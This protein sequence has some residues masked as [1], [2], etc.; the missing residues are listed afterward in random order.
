MVR[1]PPLL[2]VWLP[3]T[4]RP[5]RVEALAVA[6]RVEVM[7]KTPPAAPPLA[8]T[9][10]KSPVWLAAPTTERG[11]VAGA[12]AVRVVAPVREE[13]PLTVRPV[14]VPTP[15]ILEKDP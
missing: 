2:M 10:R 14:S 1:D 11:M 9:S 13:V 4:V 7:L 12:S 6:T 5:V 3:P 8:V 15:V